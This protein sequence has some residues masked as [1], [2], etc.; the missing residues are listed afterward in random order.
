MKEAANKKRF[1]YC[2]IITILLLLH[3][4]AIIKP[5]NKPSK[6]AMNTRQHRQSQ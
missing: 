4:V 2:F 6:Q 3:H 5:T 1:N